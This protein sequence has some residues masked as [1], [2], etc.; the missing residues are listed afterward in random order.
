MRISLSVSPKKAKDEL[1]KIR[2]CH[3]TFKKG[4]EKHWR[5]YKDQNGKERVTAQSICWLFCWAKTGMNSE[6]AEKQARSVFDNIFDHTHQWLEGRLGR[7]GRP[8]PGYRE[9]TGHERAQDLRYK[10]G[11]IEEEFD[12]LLA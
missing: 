7:L 12:S 9:A 4:L 8:S 6:Y 2:S 10:K 11:D 5:T 1:D 3:K